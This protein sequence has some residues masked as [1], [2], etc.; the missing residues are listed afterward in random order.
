LEL[1]KNK[2]Y[3]LKEN[4]KMKRKYF[5]F[6][7]VTI[8]MLAVMV[9]TGCSPVEPT[10]EQVEEETEEEEQISLYFLLKTLSNP[11]WV[12]MKEA[13]DEA[14]A[15][16]GVEVYVDAMNSEDD[17]SGQLD[18]LLTAAGQDYD[19]IGIAPISP[20]NTIEGIV[21]ANNNG[22]PVV[23]IDSKV[24]AEELAAAGGYMIGFATTD[25][26]AVGATAAQYIIDNNEPG[27][28]AI[29]EG[30]TGNFNSE[31]RKSG[32]EEALTEAGF[33][34]VSVQPADWDRNRALDVATNFISQYPDLKAIYCANDT[35]ALGAQ[36]AVE[37]A[38][39]AE[40]IMV[41]GTDGIPEAY[42]SVKD[43]AMAATVAQDPGEIGVVCLNM[44]L[45]AV[46]S[47]NPG[48]LDEEAEFKY[49]D[50]IL[51]TVDNVDDF[52]E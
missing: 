4:K 44:L 26:F 40:Q 46:R 13:I 10:P 18:K 5:V 20:T 25:N 29:I 8:A 27:E 42:Q 35:M 43:G 17:L 48:S 45:E 16:A 24:D 41:V 50:S 7:L 28:V 15:E 47:G 22:I 11:Y 23:N 6:T 21:A 37:N 36:E 33:D 38:G 34:V 14:A 1:T 12:A 2:I 49:V 32:A 9:F 39:L 31:A 19:G 52:I 30:K 51:V 3:Y